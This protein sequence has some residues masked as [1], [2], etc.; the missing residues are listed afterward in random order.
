[1]HKSRKFVSAILCGAAACGVFVCNMFVAGISAE[2]AYKPPEHYLELAHTAFSQHQIDGALENLKQLKTSAA[3][4]STKGAANHLVKPTVP[5]ARNAVDKAMQA[6][7]GKDW[8]EAERKCLEGLINCERARE[9]IMLSSTGFGQGLVDM[10]KATLYDILSRCQERQGKS[11]ESIAS[12]ELAVKTWLKCPH[13]LKSL[14]SSADRLA[15][16]Y[17][18]G[19]K[20]K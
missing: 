18:G 1:M 2:E 4:V 8:A 13:A 19:N 20:G 17:S 10:D 15:K 11:A 5:Y 7:K 6:E 14:K 3:A 16:L 12:C 9:E